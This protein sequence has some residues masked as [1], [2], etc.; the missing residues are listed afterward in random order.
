[1]AR[2]L[3]RYIIGSVYAS[4]FQLGAHDN[5]SSDLFDRHS[6]SKKVTQATQQLHLQCVEL[7]ATGSN[8]YTDWV[9]SQ[10]A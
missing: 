5:D 8:C 2:R 6:G 10:Y 9:V 7:W 3:S 4:K 1:M